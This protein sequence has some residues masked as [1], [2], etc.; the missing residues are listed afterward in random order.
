MKRFAVI[1]CSL[2]GCVGLFGLCCS[3]S[4]NAPFDPLLPAFP[5]GLQAGRSYSDSFYGDRLYFL[6]RDDSTIYQVPNSVT[7]SADKI[8]DPYD[9]SQAAAQYTL[10]ISGFLPIDG[11]YQDPCTICM[12]FPADVAGLLQLDD[13]FSADGITVSFSHDIGKFQFQNTDPA[14]V[15]P[16]YYWMYSNHNGVMSNLNPQLPD[17][18]FYMYKVYFTVFGADSASDV[19]NLTLIVHNPNSGE[20]VVEGEP[21][22]DVGAPGL[23]GFF[24]VLGDFFGMFSPIFESEA[25]A[26]VG[27]VIASGVVLGLV[28]KLV[29]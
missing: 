6:V 15:S 12:L 16:Q 27:T 2:L 24:K 5:M 9:N 17:G 26:V 22:I 29:I 18:I 14:L 28:C 4:S 13:Q 3:A 11:V 10:R 7:W 8:V 23:G 20:Y 25:V 1:L 19:V 21:P